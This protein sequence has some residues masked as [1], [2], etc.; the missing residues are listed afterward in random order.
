MK[1][2]LQPPLRLAREVDA[3]ELAELVNF[4]GEDDFAMEQVAFKAL[5]V[6]VRTL[7]T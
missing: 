5:W 3:A 7:G 1:L 4:A 2:E 6:K